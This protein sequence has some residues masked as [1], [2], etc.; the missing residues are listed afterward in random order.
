VALARPR[1]KQ[2]QDP[3]A[4]VAAERVPLVRLEP[5]HRAAAAALTLAGRRAELDLAV[6]HRDPRVLLHLVVAERLAG[7]EDDQDGAR[8]VVGVENDRIAGAVGRGELEQVPALHWKSAFPRLATLKRS[9]PLV[10]D[11][12]V[13]GPFQSNCYVVRSE[14]GAP[15]AA[16]VDPG[17]DPTA[18]R[19]ELARM[20]TRTGGIL[21][22]HTDVDHIGGVAALA[23]G[24]GADVWAPKGE[25]EALRTGETRGGL[26]VSPHDPAHTV[27]GGDEIVVAAIPFEVVDV[28]GHSSGHV[29]FHH[30]G[31]LFSGDLLFAGSVGRVDLAGGDWETLLDSV[32]ALLD[33]FPE[34]TVL[35]PGHGPSTTLGRE[36][37]TNPFLTDLR[38]ERQA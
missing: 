5:N 9:M 23:D 12:F 31:H 27:A 34:E 24:T 29:A 11:M 10:V 2:Q 19:L 38:A 16:V 6:E 28:P 30:D 33:R 13:M 14:R 32:R 17:D 35:H 37:Q 36:L 8:A 3:R 7:G 1:R 25:V 18:L 26:V 20:G 4:G 15:E 21:V 22:T